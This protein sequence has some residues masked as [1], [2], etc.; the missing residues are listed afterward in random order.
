MS[1]VCAFRSRYSSKTRQSY[2]FACLGPLGLVYGVTSGS[3]C[4]GILPGTDV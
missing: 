2:E 1:L 4:T 3:V